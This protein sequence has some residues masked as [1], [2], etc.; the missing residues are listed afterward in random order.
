[1]G[2]TPPKISFQDDLAVPI[3]GSRAVCTI[4]INCAA[5]EAQLGTVDVVL[6]TAARPT[7]NL[8]QIYSPGLGFLGMQ[9][10]EESA[11]G[12]CVNSFLSS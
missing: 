10:E 9:N 7:R 2:P 11:V 4:T 12:V 6:D 1:M 5:A 8:G 3:P